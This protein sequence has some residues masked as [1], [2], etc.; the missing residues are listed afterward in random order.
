SWSRGCRRREGDR[1]RGRPLPVPGP[2]TAP[3]ER[4]ARAARDGDRPAR[5]PPPRVRARTRAR[6]VPRRDHRRGGAPGLRAGADMTDRLRVLVVGAGLMGAQI[7]C[8]YALGGHPTSFLV[9]DVSSSR[10][11]VTSGFAL[12]VEAGIVLEDVA[13]DAASRVAFVETLE[14]VD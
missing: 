10:D 13:A 14:A 8:E 4:R 7:G 11:R 12:A 1:L 5:D 2:D 6:C 9:R 3:D